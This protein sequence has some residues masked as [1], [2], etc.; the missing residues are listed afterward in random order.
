MKK[1]NVAVWVLAIVVIILIV[2]GIW[3]GVRSKNQGTAE[4]T[5]TTTPTA[6]AVVVQDR[7][8][9]TVAAIVESLSN[10]T[11]FSSY[12]ISTGVAAT[13]TGKGPYTV[14]V[15]TN[16]A[17][18]LLKPGTISNLS[19]A[20]KKR[21]VQY[22]VVVGRA[23]D[24]DAV[25]NGTIQALSKDMLNFMASP[26]TGEA[27]VNNSYVINEYRASNGIVF[28]INAVLLPPAKN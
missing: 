21:L 14:F 11:A 3:F 10:G 7:K 22:H 25:S 15:P 27:R 28:I 18:S 5:A 13:I 16:T 24:V 17:F 6:A 12:F 19:A 20:D 1:T 23:L 9:S 4:Q 8:S 26:V 2:L